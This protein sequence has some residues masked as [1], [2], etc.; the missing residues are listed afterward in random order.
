MR[1]FSINDICRSHNLK[2]DTLKRMI[3]TGQ[4]KAGKLSMS[5]RGNLKKNFKY[6]VSED[7]LEK[8]KEFRTSEPVA[9]ENAQPDYYTKYWQKQEERHR[10]WHEEPQKQQE[11][12]QPKQNYYEY[13][14]SEAW[15]K[16]RLE[17]LRRDRFRCQM[18]GTAKNLRV[19]HINYEHLG[20][21]AE[22]DDLITLCDTCH[23]EVHEE[24]IKKKQAAKAEALKQISQ[25][26]KRLLLVALRLLR[27]TSHDPDH[28]T[29]QEVTSAWDK[30][31]KVCE[32]LM[33]SS[34]EIPPSAR[35]CAKIWL[36]ALGQI[37]GWAFMGGEA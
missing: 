2:K 24:D 34:L 11:E 14:H 10:K 19:H 4:V 23:R 28:P 25:R 22:L 35:E 15:S 26:N 17:V 30:Y 29:P 1:Y 18:C 20:T 8:L 21:D 3:R 36:E 37:E 12:N 6:I 32:A 33:K 7:E 31:N 5:K 13:M 27:E 16:R 9:S